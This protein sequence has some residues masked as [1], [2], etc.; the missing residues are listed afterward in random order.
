[1]DKMSHHPLHVVDDKGNTSPSSFIPFCELGGNMSVMGV[2]NKQFSV[3]VCNSFKP[4]VLNDR[5]C[6]RVNPIDFKSSRTS[7]E[8][9]K[10]GLIFFIDHNEDRQT[11]N[12]LET[13]Y[14]GNLFESF[15]KVHE[16]E[17][18]LIYLETIGNIS[19]LCN[20]WIKVTFSSFRTSKTVW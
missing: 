4:T 19:F 12:K 9:L 13:N 11:E 17:K 15:V 16:N 1:M 14:T 5:L 6:Y 8:D 2:K 10:K 20:S 3:P 7:V 18:A